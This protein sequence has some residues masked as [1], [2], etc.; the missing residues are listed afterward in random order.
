MCPGREGHNI[1]K[2]R[3][4]RHIAAAADPLADEELLTDAVRRTLKTVGVL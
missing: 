1:E 2:I 4:K 3:N